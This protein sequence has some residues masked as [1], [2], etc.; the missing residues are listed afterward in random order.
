[1]GCGMRLPRVVGSPFVATA[2]SSRD[3]NI[4][5]ACNSSSGSHSSL[6]V[7]H[8]LGMQEGFEDSD[9]M[10]KEYGRS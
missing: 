8:G 1:M 5:C 2:A 7:L 6:L 4:G 9:L 3:G 10:G